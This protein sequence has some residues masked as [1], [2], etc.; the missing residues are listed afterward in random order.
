[1]KELNIHY[2][3]CDISTLP[4]EMLED[5]INFNWENPSEEECERIVS[6]YKI[7]LYFYDSLKYQLD[8]K[9]TP[10][11]QTLQYD[12]KRTYERGNCVLTGTMDN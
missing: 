6:P 5:T 1:M 3:F 7:N 10:S 12:D 4:Q 9:T 2:F 11:L 8:E